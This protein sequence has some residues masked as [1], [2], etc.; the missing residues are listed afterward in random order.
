[1]IA[2]LRQP[3]KRKPSFG[4]ESHCLQIEDISFVFADHG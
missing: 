2:S 1:M 4:D 3:D